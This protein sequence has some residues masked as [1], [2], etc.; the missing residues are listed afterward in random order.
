MLRKVLFASTIALGAAGCAAQPD[1]GPRLV[2]GGDN[3]QVVYSEQSRNV[4]GG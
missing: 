3:A 1:G 4:L 2:G